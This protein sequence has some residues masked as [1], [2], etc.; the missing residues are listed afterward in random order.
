MLDPTI[1]HYIP[2]PNVLSMEDFKEAESA[3]KG[4]FFLW[5]KELGRVLTTDSLQ[6]FQ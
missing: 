1:K 5:T 2:L 6:R 3:N 4:Q